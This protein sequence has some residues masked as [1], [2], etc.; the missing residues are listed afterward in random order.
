MKKWRQTGRDKGSQTYDRRNVDESDRYL[1]A[2]VYL[3]E[4]LHVRVALRGAHVPTQQQ[5]H[6][7]PIKV[8]SGVFCQ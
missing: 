2:R 8:L 5:L 7:A 3:H 4:H 6:L 1:C